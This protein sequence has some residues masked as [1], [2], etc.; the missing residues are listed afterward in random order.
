MWLPFTAV[1]GPN[2]SRLPA[3]E[4][5]KKRLPSA[6]VSVAHIL[7]QPRTRKQKTLQ[8]GDI[9]TAQLSFDEQEQ[10]TK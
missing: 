8:N 1:S 5:R 7:T 10:S 2:V 3:E 9:S 6:V 4:T